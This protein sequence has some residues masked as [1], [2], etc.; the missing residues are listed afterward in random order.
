MQLEMA[1]SNSAQFTRLQPDC[2]SVH[3][4]ESVEVK[5]PEERVASPGIC[6][7]HKYRTVQR[8]RTNQIWTN[9][10][11]SSLELRSAAVVLS[12]LD[13]FSIF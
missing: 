9:L 5:V 1:D 2:L 13:T 6:C 11:H 7:V 4:S 10:I 3:I 8:K 12:R